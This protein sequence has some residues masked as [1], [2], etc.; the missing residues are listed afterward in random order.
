[1]FA[2]TP[3]LFNTAITIPYC[4]AVLNGING[5]FAAKPAV[6]TNHWTAEAS[7]CRAGGQ[8]ADN[9]NVVSGG[10]GSERLQPNITMRIHQHVS[11]DSAL[12]GDLKHGL[13][14]N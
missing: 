11:L 7:L 1:M 6:I 8:E 3:A 4:S 5:W 12:V 10:T 13:L 14:E 2:A 9:H